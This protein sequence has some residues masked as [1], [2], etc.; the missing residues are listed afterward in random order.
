MT[1]KSQEGKRLSERREY[2]RVSLTGR[3]DVRKNGETSSLGCQAVNISKGGAAIYSQKPYEINA[4]L[5]LTV[6]F[7]NVSG[8]ESEV[9]A[10]MIRWIK[11]VENM[12]AIGVQFKEINMESH[13]LIFSYLDSNE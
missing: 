11:P 3:I 9:I 1:G 10:G 4:E 12:F 2:T 6:F 7:K 5:V 13:P 8:E